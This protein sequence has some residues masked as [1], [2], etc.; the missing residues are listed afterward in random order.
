MTTLYTYRGTEQAPELV[1]LAYVN[2]R[3]GKLASTFAYNQLYLANPHTQPIDPELPLQ[4]GN[5]PVRYE[6]PGSFMD[7]TPDRWGRNLINKR[8]PNR[9]LNN[10]DYLLG[11][12]D[13]SR[14]GA[15]RF[16]TEQEGDFQFPDAR[17]PK[18]MA[19]SELLD[20]TQ[21]LD[22]TR[23]EAEA[24]RFLLDAGSGSLG[25]ARPKAVVEKGGRLFLAKFPHAHDT[26]DVITAEYETLVQ[27]R[28]SGMDVPECELITVGSAHVLLVERFDRCLT[29]GSNE[30]IPYI[31]AMTA[32]GAQDGEQRDYLE[33]LDFISR[34]G[35]RPRQDTLELLRRI[36]YTIEV[37]NTDDHLRNHGFLYTSGG[38][39][40]S[41]LFD[42][43]PNPNRAM[44]RQ[45]ALGGRV[46]AEGSL[47]VL[48][49]L[50]AD[51]GMKE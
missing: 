37:N 19:L 7:S 41:P 5:W 4:E 13:I 22:G 42:V 1:G 27:A 10:L 40:L 32:L 26:Y 12:S 16:K 49:E 50:E 11:V 44:P 17:V 9:R 18:L 46:D 3:R 2:Q 6:L 15:L 25:G 29:D 14:Q 28:R 20:A 30:R 23:R 33:I 45:T 38:W 24:V 8:Y 51:R 43:N 36:R 35:S 34:A 48:E 21:A 47:A 39:H 31:S